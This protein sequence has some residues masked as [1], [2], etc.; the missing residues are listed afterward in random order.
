[1]YWEKLEP[2]KNYAYNQVIRSWDLYRS[3]L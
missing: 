1:M 3:R 2:I